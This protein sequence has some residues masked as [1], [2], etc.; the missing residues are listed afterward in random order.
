VDESGRVLGRHEGLHRFTVGQRKGIGLPTS[1]AGRPLYVLALEAD[2]GRLVVG[3]RTSLERNTLTA[4][5]VN[6][7]APPE[8]GRLRITAQIRHR[9]P[10]AP[11]FVEARGQ[12]RA[13]VSFDTPQVAITPG[14]AVVFYDEEVVVG[15]GW[16]D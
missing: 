11:A 13:E 10:P 2:T 12:G 16:I 6:W 4:S 15:G 7:I 5:G 1:A 3:P 9:H 14:Q 8:N